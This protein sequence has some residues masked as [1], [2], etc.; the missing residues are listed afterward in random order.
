MSVAYQAADVALIWHKKKICPLLEDVSGIGLQP[1]VARKWWPS[2]EEL[3][4][5]QTLAKCGKKWCPSLEDFVSLQTLTKCGLI[6]SP[7]LEDFV[8]LRTLTKCGPKCALCWK[9]LSHCGLQPNVNWNVPLIGGLCHAVDFDQRW[10][11]HVPLDGGL[12]FATEFNHIWINNILIIIIEK[13]GTKHMVSVYQ[14]MQNW[15]RHL[16]SRCHMT[17][18]LEGICTNEP[19]QEN[20]ASPAYLN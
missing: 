2:S 8:S 11:K 16:W 13:A 1:N 15:N 7:L 3:V 12:C 18:T 10:S 20:E 6:M 5:Q 4:T 19:W 17:N 9:T 14:S